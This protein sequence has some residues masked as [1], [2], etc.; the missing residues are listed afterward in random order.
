MDYDEPIQMPDLLKSSEA[1]GA[2]EGLMGTKPPPMLTVYPNPSKDWVILEYKLE[3]ESEGT[4]ETK[5][6]NG[7]SIH[8]VSISEIQDQ[9]T[10]ITHNWKPGLYIATIKING[11]CLESAKFTLSK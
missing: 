7:R 8:T 10:V 3:T 6:V 2:F 1:I 4:I 9:V 5:D 11:K